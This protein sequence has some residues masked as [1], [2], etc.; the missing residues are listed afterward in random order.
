M[1][2]HLSEAELADKPSHTSFPE[3][4]GKKKND[5]SFIGQKRI[6][7]CFQEEINF[8]RRNLTQQKIVAKMSSGK[9]SSEEISSDEIG[10]CENIMHRNLTR[11]KFHAAKFPVEK[12]PVE[13]FDSVKFP[14][15][16]F[17]STKNPIFLF[18]KLQ[19]PDKCL[20]LNI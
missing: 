12:F 1:C 9:N 18:Q 7:K 17:Y 3:Y 10:R 2:H 16:K 13:K 11:R 14:A 6:K 8:P 19:K 4:R 15:A 5:W 20:I